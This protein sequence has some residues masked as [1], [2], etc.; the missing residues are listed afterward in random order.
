MIWLSWT[1]PK[2]RA[3]FG[4][5]LPRNFQQA[6]NQRHSQRN[7]GVFLFKAKD[8]EKQMALANTNKFKWEKQMA[9]QKSV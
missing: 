9:T 4:G 1:T 3:S 8:E 5:S 2:N 7:Q 6:G